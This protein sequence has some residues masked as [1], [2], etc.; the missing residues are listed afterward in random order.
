MAKKQQSRFRPGDRV[1]WNTSQGKTR[2][3][4]TKKQTSPTKIKSHKV[5]ASPHNPEYVVQSEKSGK[6]AAHKGRSLKKTGK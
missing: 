2:G 6:K 5:A 4:V 3:R 1:E